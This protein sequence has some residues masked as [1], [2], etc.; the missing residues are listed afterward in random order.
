MNIFRKL[1]VYRY[2]TGKDTSD[3]IFKYYNPYKSFY[4]FPGEEKEIEKMMWI[5]ENSSDYD[6]V[7]YS[8]LM[9]SIKCTSVNTK[10]QRMETGPDRFRSSLDIW[11]HAKHFNSKI[12]IFDVMNSLYNLREN[13]RSRYCFTVK[14]RVFHLATKYIYS[15]NDYKAYDEYLLKFDH[16]KK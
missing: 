7:V 14:R 4:D 1:L 8:C 2:L 5:A 15:R 9:L 10:T 6:A 11:R 12:T 16:W 13:L 3:L